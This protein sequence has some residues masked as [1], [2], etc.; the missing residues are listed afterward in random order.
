MRRIV[1]HIGL[2]KTGSTALQSFVA[3]N[4]AELHARGLTW[5]TPTGR[6]NHAAIAAAYTERVTPLT[7]TMGI[8]TEAERQ[9]VRGRLAARLAKQLS[10]DGTYLISSEHLGAWLR[11]P[12]ELCALRDLLRGLADEVTVVAV[13]RR[14]DYWLPSSYTE[15]VR[16]GSSQPLTPPFVR[17]RRAMLDHEQLRQ[18]WTAAFGD[19]AMLLVPYLERD[20]TDYAALPRRVLAAIGID[21][22]TR[23]PVPPRPAREALSARAVELLRLMN[24]QLPSGGLRPSRDRERLV[25]TLAERFPGRS[26]AL[27]P[28]TRDALERAGYLDLSIAD[29]PQAVGA[30]WEQW[31]AQPPAPV[32]RRPRANERQ[33]AKVLAELQRER[34]VRKADA[35]DLRAARRLLL[36]AAGRR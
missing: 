4:S 5:V 21:D 15:A 3:A 17:K 11:R 9:R 32:R 22:T 29:A 13:L 25:A 35:P 23:W 26:I 1:V 19:G 30:E 24:P 31:R 6:D 34:V 18:R 7:E 2:P 20:K 8:T 14:A 27:T 28:R 16:G 36:R 33:A 10:A 12:S